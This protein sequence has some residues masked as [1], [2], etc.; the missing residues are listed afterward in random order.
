MRAHYHRD[1]IPRRRRTTVTVAAAAA[2]LSLTL[3]ACAVIPEGALDRLPRPPLA[4][5]VTV[6]IS[7]DLLWH[8]GLVS[9]A[10]KA[11]RA[12]GRAYDFEPLFENVRHHIEDADVSV[13]H[14][15]VPVVPLGKKPSGYPAFGSPPET[16]EASKAIG[17]DYCTTASN[18]TYDRGWAGLTRTLDVLDE[19]GI[20]AAGS[21]RTKADADSAPAIFT[22]DS[23]VEVAVVAGTYDV[24]GPGPDAARAWSIDML[25][26]ERMIAR[27]RAARESGAQI[28][29]AAMHAGIEYQHKPS[30]EQTALA[31]KLARSG[32]F[33]LVYGHHAHVAQPWQ[34]IDGIWVVYGGGNLVGQMRLNTPRAW[35]QYLGRLTFERRSGGEN[36]QRPY[37]AV[38]AEYVPLLMTL[39]EPGKPARVLD[40]NRALADRRG[41]TARLTTAKE[42]IAKAVRLLGAED[43]EEVGAGV[44]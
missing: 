1:M 40:V 31:T 22:T 4:K 24:N 6:T 17:F 34:R 25:D 28:V 20:L 33:D 5:R 26:A 27:G 11:G 2:V 29:L 30:Q 8:N 42:Q 15:E 38:K 23:G 7:G 19:H 18:H 14:M 37:E 3:A 44:P 43:V 12:V 16:V 35:E 32:V 39:S 9:D 21:Y 13:C 10:A 36:G 41:D